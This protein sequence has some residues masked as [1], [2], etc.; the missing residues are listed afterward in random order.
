MRD[1]PQVATL[2]ATDP[3]N[4]YGVA[5]A[6]AGLA[7]RRIDARVAIGGARV[8]LVDGRLAAWI[9]R[10]DRQL[11][12]ALPAEEPDRSRVGRALARE[13]VR[14]AYDEPAERRGWL[15]AEINGAPRGDQPV[16]PCSGRTGLR[17][18][19][20]AGCSCACRGEP[21]DVAILPAGPGW[22]P[23][24]AVPLSGLFRSAHDKEP[25]ADHWRRS[26][27]LEAEKH[28]RDEEAP[29]L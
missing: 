19:P 2:A 6:V 7:R 28:A 29:D 20:A 27:R 12:A 4:P 26:S 8:V 10:G 13:L 18:R 23:E 17:R 5:G 24:N 21:H 25:F 11:L 1:E 16:A 14:I 22:R 15:I 9:A 3:A